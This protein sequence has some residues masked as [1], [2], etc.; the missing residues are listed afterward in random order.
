MGLCWRKGT[1]LAWICLLLTVGVV[2]AEQLPTTVFSARDGLHTLVRHI[3][4][5]SKGFLWFTG[6]EGLARFDGNGFRIFTEADGL[7]TSI[8]FDIL[9]RQDGTY[10]VGAG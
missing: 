9:E 10:W 8:T 3:V 1:L 6:S 7:P 2:R 5:D 4:V